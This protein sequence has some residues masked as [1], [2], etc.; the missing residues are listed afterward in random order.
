MQF[1]K[2]GTKFLN[3]IRYKEYL[4]E[5]ARRENIFCEFCVAKNVRHLKDCPT[6]QE[7]FDPETAHKLTKEERESLIA[8]KD[9][10]NGDTK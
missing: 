2:V 8:K 6:K 7:G 9:E 1:F 5:K 10:P 4:K 3:L